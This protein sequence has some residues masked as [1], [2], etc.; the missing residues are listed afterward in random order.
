MSGQDG[1]KYMDLERFKE[2]SI[3]VVIQDFKHPAYPQ[4]FEGFE[5]HMSVVDLLFNCG[6]G[7]LEK[8]I[9]ANRG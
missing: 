2:S 8:I 7:S 9:E 4:L 6:P 3:K 5:S 1:V